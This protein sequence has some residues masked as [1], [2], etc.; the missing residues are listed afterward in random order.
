MT[1]PVEL[2]A[3]LASVAALFASSEILRRRG[4]AADTTRRYTHACGAAM[5]ALLPAF[6]S[7]GEC[8][9]LGAGVAVILAWTRSRGLLASVHGVERPTLGATLLPVGLVLAA[10]IGWEVRPS[11]ILAALVLALADPAAAIA[12]QMGGPS[13]GVMRGRK[14]LA[15]SAAFFATVIALGLA[16]RALGAP[17][18]IGAILA[19]AAAVTVVEGSLGFGLDNLAVPPLAAI[20][21]RSALGG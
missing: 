11:Y 7:L 5:A 13:W 10:V 20:A 8:V 3:F 16:G 2:T 1:H 4:V 14:S 17:L 12:G 18:S 9:A 19:T 21:W 15:G 6:A